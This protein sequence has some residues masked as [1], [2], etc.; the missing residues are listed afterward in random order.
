V[1]L[2]IAEILGVPVPDDG[3]SSATE[4]DL[5]ELHR[6]TETA[7]QIILSNL[8]M[9]EKVKPGTYERIGG[10]RNIWRLVP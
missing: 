9:V 1:A 3:L 10:P 6:G 2:D 7:L 8:G 5:L 4:D